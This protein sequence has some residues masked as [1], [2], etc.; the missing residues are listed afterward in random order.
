MSPLTPQ[1][2]GQ[3]RLHRPALDTGTHRA[4]FTVPRRA[5]P[6]TRAPICSAPASPQKAGE[7]VNRRSCEFPGEKPFRPVSIWG[8]RPC[9]YFRAPGR[10]ERS[11]VGGRP[12]RWRAFPGSPS[13]LTM[14]LKGLHFPP[15]TRFLSARPWDPTG[16]AATVPAHSCCP[17][18]ITPAP[19]S[20]GLRDPRWE[21]SDLVEDTYRSPRARVN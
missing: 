10:G 14:G 20:P 19:K 18:I 1:A 17:G 15:D 2:G 8:Q 7:R 21:T 3:V 16:R 11:G 6:S 5:V 9:S 13:A 12:R 4:A